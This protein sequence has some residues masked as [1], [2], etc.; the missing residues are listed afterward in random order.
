MPEL[1]LSLLHNTVPLK[2][3]RL[4]KVIKIFA[5]LPFCHFLVILS[6]NSLGSW[7]APQLLDNIK[8]WNYK[9]IIGEQPALPNTESAGD[10]G[11]PSKQA[12][13]LAPLQTHV[14]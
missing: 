4:V 6:P 7:W 13:K 9:P 8:Q 5:F 12:H 3:T 1:E 14:L 11:W 2:D 10:P